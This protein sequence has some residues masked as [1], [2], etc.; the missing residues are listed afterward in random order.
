MF[1][2]FGV[3]IIMSVLALLSGTPLEPLPFLF[4]LSSARY[5][6]GSDRYLDGKTEDNPELL[7]LSLILSMSILY[8]YNH[9]LWALVEASCLQIYDPLKKRFPILKPFYV[10]T[11][12]SC[13]ITVVPHIISGVD[14]IPGDVVSMALLTS[15]ISNMADIDD[16][17]DDLDNGIYTIPVKYG[18]PATRILTSGLFLGAASITTKT[19]LLHALSPSRPRHTMRMKSHP[20]LLS[21]SIVTC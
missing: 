18:V 6:Y 8:Y 15:G 21:T 1:P 3:G 11:L 4:I 14:V 12:W 5:V 19:H 13:T 2:G 10:G 7:T 17:D 20:K 16:V 9:P